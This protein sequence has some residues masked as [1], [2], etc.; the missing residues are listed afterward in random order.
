MATT[1]ASL[2]GFEP[3]LQ[4]P[5]RLQVMAVLGQVHDA[6]FARLRDITRCSDSV[7]S[8]HLASL[9]DAGLI[10][11]R[12]AAVDGRQRTWAK[13]TATGRKRFDDHVA[14]LKRIIDGAGG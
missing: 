2:D 5:A 13:M 10:T 4:A 8:K 11:L 14:A 3:L 12:K 6:E 9:A 1:Q 7:L